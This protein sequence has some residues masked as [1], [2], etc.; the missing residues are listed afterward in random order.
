MIYS[1]SEIDAQCKK[2]ARGAGFE[3]G[4]AEEAGK[5]ARWLAAMQLPGAA[6]LAAYLPEYSEQ[7]GR[8]QSPYLRDGQPETDAILCPISTGARICDKV[9]LL[10]DHPLSVVQIV[11]PLLLLPSLAMISRH[12][13]LSIDLSWEGAEVICSDGRV[14][15]LDHSSL[16]TALA[17]RVNLQVVSDWESAEQGMSIGTSGQEVSDQDWDVLGGL[18][19]RTYVP[20]TEASRLGAGPAD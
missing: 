15:I 3:W 14:F 10:I 6:L 20:A 16:T 13:Q 5:S 8:Y 4:H 19:H 12:E 18:A 2:A 11:Y 7:A 9:G 17:S 1:L